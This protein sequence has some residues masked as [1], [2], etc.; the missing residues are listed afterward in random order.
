MKKIIL[1]IFSVF[2]LQIIFAQDSTAYRYLPLSIGNV[3]VYQFQ[4]TSTYNGNSSGYQIVKVTANTV[5]NS[6]TYFVI[7]VETIFI[8]GTNSCGPRVFGSGGQIRVDSLTGKVFGWQFCQQDSTEYMIDSLNSKLYDSVN[9]CYSPG[10]RIICSDTTSR[11]IFQYTKR[12]LYFTITGVESGTGWR[13]IKDF[14]IINSGQ[15]NPFYNCNSELK[16]C[17]INNILYGDTS[18]VIGIQTISSEIPKS[19]SL[20]QN[21]PNP[22]NPST[23]ITFSILLLRGVSGE[24]G[25][26]VLSSITIYNSIGQKITELFNQ[27]LSPGTYSV[28]WH[29]SNQPSGLYFYTLT[30]GEYSETKRM[31]LIK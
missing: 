13:Y 7:N 6:K 25:R 27:Q 30:S 16:G 2:C 5:H 31:V 15:G 18:T 24:G 22:F 3:W 21:Y 12:S 9:T 19:Y 20:I 8:Q 4:Y 10:T 17:L 1:I 23:K 14:G 11:N 29:A 26:G 28:E